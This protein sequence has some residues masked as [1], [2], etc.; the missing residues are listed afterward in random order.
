MTG[1][2]LTLAANIGLSFTWELS[3]V[4]FSC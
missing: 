4:N 3:C 1:L 2:A